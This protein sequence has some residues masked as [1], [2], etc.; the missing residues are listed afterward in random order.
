[1]GLPA[2]E[3]GELMLDGGRGGEGVQAGDG[4]ERC[5]L[6]EEKRMQQVEVVGAE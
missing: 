1:L 6:V 4:C 5:G 3:L 2:L